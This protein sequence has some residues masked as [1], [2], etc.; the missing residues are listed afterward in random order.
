MQTRFR[1]V[2]IL[3]SAARLAVSRFVFAFS[4]RPPWEFFSLE[5][6]W[7]TMPPCRILLRPMTACDINRLSTAPI[8]WEWNTPGETQISYRENVRYFEFTRLAISLF[9]SLSADERRVSTRLC[10]GNANLKTIFFFFL[11]WFFFPF[12]FSFFRV[13]W[14]F[15]VCVK[16]RGKRFQKLAD[17]GMADRSPFTR[18]WSPNR[19]AFRKAENTRQKLKDT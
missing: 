12:F 17:F 10:F 19:R 7:A 1:S 5:W 2:E 15:R 8:P 13:S 16:I 18:Q 6:L 14:F 4:S 9:L 3:P 11:L